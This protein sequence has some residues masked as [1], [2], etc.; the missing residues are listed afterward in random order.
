MGRSPNEGVNNVWS[1]AGCGKDNEQYLVLF[2]G[3]KT[4]YVFI[5]NGGAV[6]WKSAKQSIFATSSIEAKYIAAFDAS[7][8]AVW[9]RK[10]ISGLGVVSTIEEPISMY[11]DNTGAITIENESGITKG[12][13]H[14]RAKFHYLHE[15][16]EFGD[17]KLEKVHT[18]DNLAEPFTKALAFQSIQN[19]LRILKCFQ[20]V[21]NFIWIIRIV[22]QFYFLM[23]KDTSTAKGTKGTSS[24]TLG[25]TLPPP[26]NGTPMD[27]SVGALTP[28]DM[29]M[30]GT[31]VNGSTGAVTPTGMMDSSSSS[32]AFS[33]WS[34]SRLLFMGMMFKVVFFMFN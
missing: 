13:R 29:N 30:N 2:I 25:A 28:L 33:G 34:V 19:I 21:V 3:G 26:Q 9:V 32:K 5:L 8:E 16:I 22:R 6:D 20:L 31:T 18:Y 4:G 12:A 23:N 1:L 10:F 7:K 24:P 15:V 14:F 27:G 11:C 17:I